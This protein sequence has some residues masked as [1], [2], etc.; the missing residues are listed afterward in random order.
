[1][2]N[3]IGREKWV[4][5]AKGLGIIAVVIG[6]SDNKVVSQY[7][8]WF[9]MPLFFALSGYLFKPLS[10]WS[11]YRIW[12]Y[13][14][15]KQQLIPYASFFMLIAVI[16]YCI[17]FLQGNMSFEI[18]NK[19]FLGL[20]YGGQL[21]VG[22]YSPFW[23]ITCLYLTQIIFAAILVRF[24]STRTQLLIIG[25]AYILA[26][27]ESS[28]AKSINIMVPWNA[29][30]ALIALC[31]Y[32]FGFYGKEILSG[33]YRKGLLLLFTIISTIFVLLDNLKLLEFR[34]DLKYLVYNNLVLDLVIPIVLMVA[35]IQISK[36]ISILP[37]IKPIEFL[38]TISLP[39][40][41]LHFPINLWLKNFW[42]DT[43]SLLFTLV[44][45]I[46]PTTITIL[47]FQRFSITKYFFLGILKYAPRRQRRQG[48]S[49][50]RGQGLVWQTKV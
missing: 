45:I 22:F 18:I 6:H 42:G 49:Q 11:E 17:R 37:F 31:Y 9:H 24:K 19:D 44:G 47:I 20:I 41:Y 29:D 38:G 13:K 33:K 14:R 35:L 27:V 21:L 12:S 2:T 28:I 46:L 32:A 1:M 34:L 8:Y 50:T 3:I 16:S 4:D 43:G 5:I 7:L 25:F 26:H 15:F 30:V 40:M 36:I 48:D 10:T 23:F 39:I